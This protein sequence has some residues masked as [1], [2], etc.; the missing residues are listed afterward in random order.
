MEH[1]YNALVVFLTLG[2]L[3]HEI[4]IKRTIVFNKLF[5]YEMIFFDFLGPRRLTKF[6]V[7]IYVICMH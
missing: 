1:V 2:Q 4:V 6:H 3:N 7:K 5:I